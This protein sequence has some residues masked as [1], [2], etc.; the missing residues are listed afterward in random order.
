MV[1]SSTYILATRLN[2]LKNNRTLFCLVISSQ[3]LAQE[4]L[5][6][7]DNFQFIYINVFSFVYNDI[8]TCLF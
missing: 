5:C 4:L 3:A 7:E 8:V 2:Y 6:I 1:K